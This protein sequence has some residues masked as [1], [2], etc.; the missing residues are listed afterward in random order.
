MTFIWDFAGKKNILFVCVG[1]LYKN[2]I[3]FGE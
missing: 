2:M 3:W 1:S